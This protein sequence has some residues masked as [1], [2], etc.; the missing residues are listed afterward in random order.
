MSPS[1]RD[2][3][4]VSA[5]VPDS[6]RMRTPTS[7]LDQSTAACAY[8]RSYKPHPGMSTSQKEVCEILLI[9]IQAS[10]VVDWQRPLVSVCMR[11]GLGCHPRLARIWQVKKKVLTF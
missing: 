7:D 6:L 10:V 1:G 11:W 2:L 8:V 4:G 5:Y 3:S 9:L